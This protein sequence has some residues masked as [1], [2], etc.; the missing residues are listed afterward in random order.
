MIVNDG[1]D[2]KLKLINGARKASSIIGSTLGRKGGLCLI[3]K[4]YGID[5]TKDGVTVSRNIEF[6][7]PIEN[8]GATIIK[9]AC[10]KTLDIAGDGTTTTAILSK[11]FIDYLNNNTGKELLKSTKVLKETVD[12]LKNVL[13]ENAIPVSKETVRSVAYTSVNNDEELTNLIVEALDY[14]EDGGNVFVEQSKSDKSYVEFVKGCRYE[15]GYVSEDF[16]N[17]PKDRKVKF[18]NP[19]M[20]I[21]T[22]TIDDLHVLDNHL[23]QSVNENR[24]LFI[25]CDNILSTSLNTLLMNVKNYK[26]DICV[27]KLPGFDRARINYAED[28]TLF[29]NPT[30]VEITNSHF[31]I[32]PSKEDK[33]KVNN[34][35]AL[36]SKQIENNTDFI[37]NEHL[38]SR[39]ESLIGLTSVINVAAFTETEY[40]EIKDR[41]EDAI[42]ACKSS[43]KY[44]ILP[45][46]GIAILIAANI[47]NIKDNLFEALI[48][49]YSYLKNSCDEIIDDK[50]IIQQRA[51]GEAIGIILDTASFSIGKVLENNIADT[52]LTLCTALDQAYNAANLLMSTNT[53]IIK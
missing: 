25:V 9:E 26:L 22:K 38:N 30:Y 53:I 36:L 11:A 50:K 39:V 21:T 18:D 34:K 29:K 6:E 31:I 4:P 41:L 5:I 27:C 52:A 23:T 10:E 35:L 15:S 24:P 51:F 12:K 47:L 14:I 37:L 1:I 49:P 8:I 3:Q 13:K 33:K 44:G 2:A 19:I 32:V 7:D 42:L 16:I 17:S 46:A 48:A 40:N 43:K 45:G 20:Y 28:L